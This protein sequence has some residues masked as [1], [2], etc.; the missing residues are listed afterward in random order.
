MFLCDDLQASG[1]VEAGIVEYHHCAFWQFWKQYFLK[2]FVEYSRVA[3][4]GEPQWSEQHAHQQ[5]RD[6][7]DAGAAI[8]RTCG[9]AALAFWAATIGIG[10]VI[11]DAGFIHPYAQM[12]WYFRQFLQEPCLL[13]WTGFFVVIGL[14]FLV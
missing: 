6:D 9:K 11:V 8:T 4:A 10:F 2:P 3:H 12:F 14:F 13:F 5:A 7:T 1:C